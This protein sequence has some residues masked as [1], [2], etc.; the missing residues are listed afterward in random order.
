MSSIKQKLHAFLHL[1][2]Y[3]LFTYIYLYN[4]RLFVCSACLNFDL[5]ETQGDNFNEFPFDVNYFMDLL[6]N[7]LE[8]QNIFMGTTNNVNKEGLQGRN[9]NAM[10]CKL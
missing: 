3:F 5:M 2:I 9:L 6:L 4:I 1:N 10:Y 7:K 8:Y